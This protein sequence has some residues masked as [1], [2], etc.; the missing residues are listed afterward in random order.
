[1]VL[2]GI[3]GDAVMTRTVLSHIEGPIGG[4]PRIVQQPA[5]VRCPMQVPIR[6]HPSLHGIFIFGVSRPSYGGM[7]LSPFITSVT[8]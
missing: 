2:S 5:W 1:M 4:F 7:F 6:I 8:P 3:T